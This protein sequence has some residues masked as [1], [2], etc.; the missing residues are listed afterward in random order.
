MV[1]IPILNLQD[2]V[3]EHRAEFLAAFESVLDSTQFILGPNVDALEREF[4]DYIGTRF[5]VSCNSGTDALLIGLRALGVGPGDEV[6]TTPF[7]FFATAEAISLAGAVPVFVDIDPAS[8]NIDVAGIESRISPRTKAILPVHLFGHSADMGA[9]LDIAQRHGLKVLEDVAQATGSEYQG[10]RAGGLGDLG[11]FSFFPT[12]NL[13]AFGDGGMMTTNDETVAQTCRMLRVHGS[14]RRYYNEVIGY[15]SRLDEIQAA[16]LRVKLKYLQSA[17]EGRRQAASRYSEVLQS[18]PGV[19]IPSEAEYTHHVFNQYTV[20]I[21]GGRRGEVQ[22][23]LQ[24][25]GIGTMLYYP[26]PLH[27]LPM[28][29]AAGDSL[30]LA[31]QAAEEV[32]SLPLWPTIDPQTQLEV[33]HAIRGALS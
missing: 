26:V 20:R 33:T 23:K 5:A 15:N 12:K 13:G 17:N 30:P 3:R 32:I 22:E 4:A 2:E 18:V 14:R 28:Y 16:F 29:V 8:L 9:L 21:A 25:A 1:R 7:S 11:A 6:I 27:R 19:T 24:A 10:R 31:E